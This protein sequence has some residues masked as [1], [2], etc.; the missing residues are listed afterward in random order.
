MP[1]ANMLGQIPGQFDNHARIYKHM[2][3]VPLAATK[4][5]SAR[6]SS[7]HWEVSTVPS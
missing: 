7:I 4:V 5:R 2:E 6:L 1:I 3:A